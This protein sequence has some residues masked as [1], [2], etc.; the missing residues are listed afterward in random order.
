[1]Q[2]SVVLTTYNC[3]STI[4]SALSSITNL[5][6]SPDEVIIIDDAS[7][8]DTV[9]KI[10]FATLDLANVKL[11][12]NPIN[13]GQ[14]YSR[15]LGVKES[16]TENIIIMDDDDCS[17]SN[18]AKIQLAAL[19]KG[20]DVSYVSSLKMYPNGYAV[21]VCNSDF[22]SSPETS[23]KIIKHLVAGVPLADSLKL[24]SPSC[25]LAFKKS[26]FL[27][28]NG[29]REDLRR[30]E[31]IEFA[32]RSLRN[33]LVLDWSSEIS[34]ERFHTV[35]EDKSASANFNGELALLESVRDLFGIREFFVARQMAIFRKNYFER[36]YL[37][38]LKSFYILPLLA[39]IAPGKVITV[40]NR[41]K[42]DISQ[43]A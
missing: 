20:V 4:I 36:N 26:S 10:G 16:K 8:D 41:L 9:N 11:I 40:V 21:E 30:L 22:T 39:L 32:C 28:I 37:S 18:R 38:I 33:G 35:G 25:S 19:A 3:S 15:N 43:R 17:Y 23:F 6:P 5:L 27:K 29:F 42:H 7:Q 12:V 24:F 2:Y 13:K 31:D 1:M 14:S 34:L